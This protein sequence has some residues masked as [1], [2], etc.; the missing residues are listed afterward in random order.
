MATDA[1]PTPPAN[2]VKNPLPPEPEFWQVYSKHYEFPLSTVG[3]IAAHVF[4]FAFLVLL[5]RYAMTGKDKTSVPI[6]VVAVATGNQD[7]DGGMDGAIG[8]G[9]DGTDEKVD[10]KEPTENQPPPPETP[11]LV[12]PKVIAREFMPQFVNDPDAINQ[13]A[14]NEAVQAFSKMEESIRKPLQQGLTKKSDNPDGPGRATE[15]N[16]GAGEGGSGGTITSRRVMRWTLRFNTRDGRDYLNQLDA[17]GAGIMIPQPPDFR[18]AHIIR[19]LKTPNSGKEEDLAQFTQMH[20]SDQ[21]PDSV[22]EITR[23]L[24][25]DFT[26]PYFTAFFPKEFEDNLAA[27]EKAYR[28][29]K[30]E[31]I[32]ET[33]FSIIIRAGKPDVK[34]VEQTPLRR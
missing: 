29:R 32:R 15:G 33:V 22:K 24:K 34:V 18:T 13:F 11:Q 16:T 28:G 23:A 30:E 14:K 1:K 12:D 26:P 7:G 2:K 3:S 8:G 6:K 10:N 4:A 21:R 9:S 19:D 20:F 25:L 17:M 27:Q 31:D 5:L